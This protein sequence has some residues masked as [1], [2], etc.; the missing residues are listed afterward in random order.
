MKFLL[1]GLGGEQGFD[2]AAEIEVL[3]RRP[4]RAPRRARPSR[5]RLPPQSSPRSVATA[6]GSW[7]MSAYA[8][9]SRAEHA[10][11]RRT[12]RRTLPTE[13]PS[14]VAV[15]S[16]LKPPKKRSST[17]RAFRRSKPARRSSASS[18]ATSSSSALR[19]VN[20]RLVE[21]LLRLPAAA[22]GYIMTAR[23]IDQNLA[24]QSGGEPEEMRSA[25]HSG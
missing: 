24:H 9:S 7:G 19:R 18:S 8:C 4:G 17:T 23:V 14:A 2:F 10:S 5:N 15:S 1:A 16:R 20:H 22:L 6:P 25:C 3:R 12:S 11:A 13:T 21:R